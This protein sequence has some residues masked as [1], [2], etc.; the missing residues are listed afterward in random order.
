[1]ILASMIS[2]GHGVG[3]GSFQARLAGGVEC[4]DCL[5][6]MVVLA[7]FIVSREN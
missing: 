2:I 7:G 4:S 1:M 3:D 6:R 5:P